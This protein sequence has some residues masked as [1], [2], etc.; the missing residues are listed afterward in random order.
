MDDVVILVT[1]TLL[2]FLAKSSPSLAY[3]PPVP[4]D[5]S[6]TPLDDGKQGLA[7]TCSLSAI[8]SEHELTNFSV[9]PSEHTHSLTVKCRDGQVKS[10]LQPD[11]F[12]SLFRLRELAI[13]DCNLQSIPARAF[14]G[15]RMLKS[16]RIKT[17][18][19]S[20]G[21]S[22]SS[23]AFLG[24]NNLEQ[25]D[26]SWNSIQALASNALCPLAPRLQL[27][28]LSHNAIG[29]LA[30]L[31]S[32]L[33]C[34]HAVRSLDLSFNSLSV[35]SAG[36]E[37]ASLNRV[38][39]LRLNDNFI[40]NLKG[41]VLKGKDDLRFLDLSNNR[42]DS[43]AEETFSSCP[44]LARIDLSNNSLSFLPKAIFRGQTRSLAFL[45]LSGNRLSSLQAPLLTGL[46]QLTSL[47]LSR[48][49]LVSVESASALR[50]LSS[51]RTLKLSRNKLFRLP[52]LNLP[53]LRAL[54]LS[55]N[56]LG[57]RSSGQIS[58][59]LL[60]R[61][62]S[63]SH[64]HLDS[65]EISELPKNFFK[66][67]SGITV[68]DLSNNRLRG[69]I[70]EAVNSLVNLQSFDIGHNYLDSLSNLQLRALWRF[71]ASGNRLGNVSADQLRG[72][73][74]LQVV[75]FSS[76][77]ISVIEKNAFAENEPL[78]AIR[79]DDNQLTSVANLFTHLP[80]LNWLNVS[81]NKIEVFDYAMVPKTL[82]WL[83]LHQNELTSL[84]NYFG[85]GAESQLSHVDAS[86]NRLRELGPQN[87]P[88]NVE[89]F[90]VNDNTIETLVPYTFFKTANLKKV[91]LS[92]NR[93]ES[94]ERNAL[95]LAS[96]DE[97]DENG[98]HYSRAKFLLG[99]NPIRCDCH[100]AWFK[101]VNE[102]VQQQNFPF[103][104]DLESIYCQLL[105]TRQKSFVPLVDAAS[106][107]FL[108]TYK[109]HCFALCHCCEYDACDCE[110]TCPDNCT[111]YHDTTWTK[112]IAE[113]SNAG[114]TNL[115]EQLPMDATEIFLDG[116]N[117]IDLESH[118]FIGRKN[119]KVV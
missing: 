91:D 79:L 105:N 112:N 16:L 54:V 13:E 46:Q 70:P 63:I 77:R 48:N 60:S 11:G 118:T 58:A 26:L 55:E 85:I 5:C 29:S 109:T 18:K 8:N 34:L 71:Q 38:Q 4:D 116:N 100:M 86:F 67:S 102:E 50:G 75:D 96:E 108:C 44:Q 17:S 25:L 19:A 33:E 41:N 43:L 97:D 6:A 93:L 56:D 119:L 66:N 90:L 104:A 110:M 49:E 101:T 83:D 72:L 12:V 111:C 89:T 2:L 69:S 78:Q 7:L 106:D 113:C 35:L 84:E 24:L 51:L 61:L 57:S 14:Y 80:N 1:T 27:L 87:V 64:L 40:R 94:I 82:T 107:Q 3:S 32:S 68:L 114:F 45:D 52:S 28:N 117:I 9:V 99:G 74:V 95:R 30:D 92:V 81:A 53:S 42:L 37:L 22:V 10:R 15:L 98:G 47:D 20:N 23:D 88:Q 36:S 21:V 65:N 62:P 76:N 31:G 39:E 103:V 115:P 59:R 73:P